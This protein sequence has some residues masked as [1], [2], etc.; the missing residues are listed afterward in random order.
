MISFNDITVRT[1]GSVIKEIKCRGCRTVYYFVMWR[2]TSASGTSPYGLTDRAAERAA[3]SRAETRLRYR[4]ATEIDSVPCPSC[5]RYQPEMF[6]PM[7]VSKFRWLRRTAV[8]LLVLVPVSLLAAAFCSINARLIPFGATG[9]IVFALLAVC[10]LVA[11][12][13]VFRTYFR[14]KKNYDPNT[15]PIDLRLAIARQRTMTRIQVEELRKAARA[16]EGD[17]ADK[18]WTAKGDVTDL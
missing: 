4:L 14:R 2:K 17:Q 11:A 8:A 15:E 13:A 9:A 7:A 12:V 5:G 16:G 1:R 18:P 10:F 6:L 3:R